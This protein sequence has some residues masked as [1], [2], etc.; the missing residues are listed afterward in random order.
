ME[1]NE[2]E[3]FRGKK[4]LITGHT[5]FK[6]SWLCSVLLKYGAL[7]S[8]FSLPISVENQ[9][10]KILNLEKRVTH[11][12]GDIRNVTELMECISAAQPEIVIHLA[13][14]ALVNTSIAEPTDTITT[15]VIGGVNLLEAV[16]CERTVKSVVFVTSDKCY[17]NNEWIWGY[18]ENDTLGGSDPYSASKACAE[19]IFNSY[20][21]TYFSKSKDVALATAR[22]GNVIGGG[23]WSQDRIIPDCISAIIENREIEIRNP[24]STRPWQHVLEPLSGYLR[25][26]QNLYQH[27][28]NFSGSW[29]FGPSTKDN[30]TVEE[31][32]NFL[33]EQL[34]SET[35]I[36][37]NSNRDSVE[38]GLLQLNCDKAHIELNWHPTWNVKETLKHTADWYREFMIAG[39]LVSFTNQQI[40]DFFERKK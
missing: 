22:A 5:G 34:N 21:K 9:L 32:V 29:N 12:E 30:F 23:D 16:K 37:I 6:G 38:A 7:V 18:R 1:K 25:L 26:A 15:N 39:D 33:I 24:K 28:S 20:S 31:V 17:Q 35:E 14:Q 13:A 10:F 2:L 40:D 19:I 11:F 8:G 4:V 3:F 27:G 36:K